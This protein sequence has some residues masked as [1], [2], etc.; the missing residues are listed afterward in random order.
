MP[1]QVL[2]HLSAMD[3]PP[4]RNPHTRRCPPAAL[5]HAAGFTLMELMITVVIAGI[6]LMIAVPSFDEM[7]RGNRLTTETNDFISAVHTARAEAARLRGP[8][9]LR[10]VGGV[11]GWDSDAGF[12]VWAELRP[13]QDLNRD[14]DFLDP[15]ESVGDE[16]LRRFAGFSDG[17]QVGPAGLPT[18]ITFLPNGLVQTG[19]LQMELCR[20]GSAN[21]RRVTVTSAGRVS[22]AEFKR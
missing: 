5:R 18:L 21:C 3:M 14:G 2:L 8:V 9:T 22:V 17:T 10:P 6:L 19:T 1:A 13:F 7:I 16:S 15:G 20:E 12:E 4:L 11:G